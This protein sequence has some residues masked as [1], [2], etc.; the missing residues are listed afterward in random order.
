MKILNYGPGPGNCVIRPGQVLDVKSLEEAGGKLKEV[1]TCAKA[2]VA[3]LH[4]GES[5]KSYFL[6]KVL[7][8]SPCQLA[9]TY[10]RTQ[11]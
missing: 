7:A 4:E 8:C 9:A 3:F 6:K 10:V 2:L 1:Y 5:V 11:P